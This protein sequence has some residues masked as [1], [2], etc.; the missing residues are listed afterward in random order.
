[1][2][3]LRSLNRNI[4]TLLTTTDNQPNSDTK[5]LKLKVPDNVSC[6]AVIRSK[7]G[8]GE[9][10]LINALIASF[11]K[12]SKVFIC[13]ENEL[14]INAEA[15]SQHFSKPIERVVS[16][17]EISNVCGGIINLN[18][19]DKNQ[20]HDLLSE[21][22]HLGEDCFIVFSQGTSPSGNIAERIESISSLCVQI[23]ISVDIHSANSL[24]PALD[25]AGMNSLDWEIIRFGCW[26][27]QLKDDG[28]RHDLQI[29]TNL[30][31][32]SAYY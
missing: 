13:Y 8:S 20:I 27:K 22:S 25:L 16:I 21:L 6:Y 7:G 17:K 29:L 4:K 32:K 3:K 19:R 31:L 24:S 14:E 15:V 5:N 11:P 28:Y 2:P 30:E 10:H 26:N 1:M 23:L 9:R 18:W 12:R